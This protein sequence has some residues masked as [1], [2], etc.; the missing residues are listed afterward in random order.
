MS[1]WLWGTS[2][3]D[4]M[5]EKATSELRVAGEEDIAL[6]LEICDQIRSKTVPPKTA[7]QSI[8]KRLNHQNPNVQLLTLSLLDTCVKNGGDH[9]LV[10]IASRE[11]MDNLTSILKLPALNREVKDRMLKVVQIWAVAFEGKSSLSYVNEVYKTLQ[12]EGFTF[13]PKD[14]VAASSVMVDT[15]TAPEWIDSD[16]CLRCRT[17]FSFTNRKHHCRNCGQVFDQACSSKTLPLPQFGIAEP[18]RVC[19]SC[20]IKLKMKNVPKSSEDTTSRR[21]Q[22]QPR[23]AKPK[24]AREQADEDLQRAIELSL[25]ESQQGSSRPGYV[26]ATSASWPGVSEPPEF[27]R[28]TRPQG[29]AEE[30]E[31]DPELRAA[32]EASLR[33]VQAPRPS[34][35]VEDGMTEQPQAS[36]NELQLSEADA[37]MTFS[38]TIQEAS[39]RGTRDL[40]RYP[41]V[42]ELLNRANDL[43]PKLAAGLEESIEK[44][45]ALTDMHEKLS[46]IVRLYD[47]I[48][49]EQ[50]TNPARRYGGYSTQY[51]QQYQAAAP[52]QYAPQPSATLTQPNQYAV[53]QQQWSA[54]PQ[55]Y[56]TQAPS[57]PPQMIST[58]HVSPVS[59]P[60]PPTAVPMSP[61]PVPIPAQQFPITSGPSP[62]PVRSYSQY[63]Q[64][65]VN[66]LSTPPP[67][68]VIARHQ[69]PQTQGYRAPSSPVQYLHQTPSQ[70][71]VAYGSSQP[72]SSVMAPPA[73]VQQPVQAPVHSYVPSAPLPSF[74]SAPTT[75]PVPYASYSSPAFE[76]KEQK[77][78]MLISFD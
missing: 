49:T 34:A 69:E 56:A 75:A 44:E 4:E 52:T 45:R 36:S 46:E 3:F 58:S 54:P 37:I 9:F 8:K 16:V 78:A 43:T 17:A 20:F 76:Q 40:V 28:S 27:D 74:P 42:S 18:V 7:M 39:A 31:D 25:R 32:I 66:Q 1:S 48:L 41:G 14:S 68:P 30:E 13:P 72:P 51:S 19:D 23:P 26:P 59:V 24:S 29:P 61:P 60:P 70:P 62:S 77:E 10:E 57:A 71:T 73:P 11:F 65:T 5:L 21:S 53:P 64:P 22:S 12:R 63:Q 35:P 6:N 50:I 67:P 2:P 38:Q 33:D 47:R 55:T 15:S